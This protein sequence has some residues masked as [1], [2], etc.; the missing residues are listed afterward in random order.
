M[1]RSLR[2]K[3]LLA[4]L[5][6]LFLGIFGAKAQNIE[7]MGNDGL[8]KGNAF[9]Q[10]YLDTTKTY[11]TAK[12]DTAD[13]LFSFKEYFGGLGHKR[14]ARIGVVAGGSTI[15]VGGMQ[16]YNKDYWK[17]PIVYG[18][19]GAG[20]GLG[21]Y[22]NS[23]YKKSG[24]TDENSHKAMMWSFIGAGL[25]YWGSFMD[26]VISYKPN[27]YPHPGKAT[28]YSIL[29]PGLGQIYN[30]EY[31][32]LPLYW[33]GMGVALSFYSDNKN[34]YIRFRDIYNEATTPGSGYDGPISADT[35]KYYRDVYRRYR[36]YSL[37][38]VA[39][40]YLLQIIDANVFSYM[41]NFEVDDNISL[42]INPTVI[43]P[44]SNSYAFAPVA[45]QTAIG[46][47]VGLTF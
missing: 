3:L 9:S 45:S 17:L 42:R 16:I 38:A 12:K 34:N 11:S 7:G 44:E 21:I 35:A 10:S 40:V 39:A 37:L 29:L 24:Y 26:G 18:G 23:Q 6:A 25:C 15:F 28:L 14:S 8:F 31:W 19:I 47:S 27:D 43:L 20:V 46:M 2:N 33:G 13:V 4:S 1:T 41:H 5:T 32:K 36:D 22:Y 30:R